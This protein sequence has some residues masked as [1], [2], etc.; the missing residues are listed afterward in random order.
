MLYQKGQILLIVILVVIV[1]STI[2]L[3]LASRSIT[4]IRT[5]TEEADSQRALAAAE[6]GIERAIQGSTLSTGVAILNGNL[7]N[8]ADYRVDV[9]GI[10]DSSFLINGGNAIPR[11]EGADLWFA[12][13]DE[14]GNIDNSSA[15]S[16]KFVHLYWS[17]P[18]EICGTSTAPAA[19]QV[20]VITRSPSSLNNIKS[21]RYVF[22]NCLSRRAENYFKEADSG[23]FTVAGISGVTFGVRTPED[24]ANKDLSSVGDIVLM[25]VIPLYK[26]AVI[27]VSACNRAGN[28]CTSLPSQGYAISSTGESG[29]ASRKLTVFKGYPQ[30]YLPYLSYGLFVA[31]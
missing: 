31:N 3:S 17:S 25:R 23:N 2:G 13:H 21:Y 27:G 12:D 19:L 16:P 29:A 4:S 11:D 28:N 15:M 8:N 22:D 24:G 5:S 20:V 30:I 18:S 26:D 10:Q 1:T 6:A 7:S 9:E 14:E